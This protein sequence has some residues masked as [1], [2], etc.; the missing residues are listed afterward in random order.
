MEGYGGQ[1]PR[2]DVLRDLIN[3]GAL[4]TPWCF[5]TGDEPSAECLAAPASES[6]SLLARAEVR[7]AGC[8]LPAPVQ[9]PRTVLPLHGNDHGRPHRPVPRHLHP[10]RA[11]H[12][13]RRPVQRPARHPHEA[14]GRRRRSRHPPERLRALR[15]DAR[16]RG[17][18][19][20]RPRGADAGRGAGRLPPHLEADR[21]DRR[22]P[23]RAGDPD[24]RRR[25]PRVERPSGQDL[26]RRG[27][28]GER[29]RSERTIRT[30][31]RT[32]AS[33]PRASARGRRSSSSSSWSGTCAPRIGPRLPGR[34]PGRRPRRSGWRYRAK[35]FTPAHPCEGSECAARQPPDSVPGKYAFLGVD[36]RF[37]T[38][39]NV[40]GQRARLGPALRRGAEPLRDPRERE[41]RVPVP[42][43]RR[44]RRSR[45]TGGGAR[46]APGIQGRP[47]AHGRGDARRL[48][49]LRGRASS[50]SR[51]CSGSTTPWATGGRSRSR[52]RSW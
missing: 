30:T 36:T 43:G 41:S 2:P 49:R 29:A 47:R 24:P 35:W 14:G 18:L 16:R 10:P 31:F 3:D 4:E 37:V 28:R 44:K 46:L 1:P 21:E 50:C 6:P 52:G 23:D 5:G 38:P 39:G 20:L 8:L 42:E 22:D 33:P 26:R 9:Q 45:G 12:E 34:T 25:L 11:R 13:R 27:G 48:R 19:L 17:L 32:R 7:P 15:A 51:G 40:R